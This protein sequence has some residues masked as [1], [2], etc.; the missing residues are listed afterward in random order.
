MVRSVITA[1]SWAVLLCKIIFFSL[2]TA[3]SSQSQSKSVALLSS[4]SN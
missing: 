4:L 1:F 2:S 3:L